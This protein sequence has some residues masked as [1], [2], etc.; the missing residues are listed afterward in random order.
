MAGA[1]AF[2]ATAAY[3][4]SAAPAIPRGFNPRTA[5]AVGARDYWILGGYRCGGTF[6]N[7]L[8]RST[9]AGKHFRREPLPPIASQGDIPS[10]VFANASIGYVVGPGGRLYVTRDGGDSWR[11]AGAVHMHKIVVAGGD[12]YGLSRNRLERSPVAKNAWHSISLPVRLRFV[13]SVAARGRRV[14][15][16]GSKRNVRVGDVTLR[17]TDGGATFAKSHG[18][19]IPELA[20]TL[21]PA[22]GGVVWAICP[23]GMMAGL[24]LSTNGGR[25][26]PRFRSFHDPGGIGLP[27]LTNGAGIYPISARAAVLYPGAQGPLFRTGDTGKRWIRVPHTARIEEAL[28]L[29]FGTSR[30]G[31]A[32]FT[33]RSRPDQA[34]FWR[35]TDGGATWH[36][37]PIR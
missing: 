28:W 32:L 4:R 20:G 3:G 25:T 8:L 2:V 26:F 15:L 18:P 35:T 11:S 9:D 12:V 22:G 27:A 19:C 21:V 10:L 37:V 30:V 1:V 24:S 29:G 13:V 33:T 5:A 34:S 23:S 6:C 31:A 36:S 16:L 7:A 14:W 17:S